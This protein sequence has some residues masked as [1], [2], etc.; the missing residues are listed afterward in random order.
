MSEFS[1]IY[2]GW[3]RHR[4]FIPVVNRFRYPIF[5]MYLDIDEIR[6]I[7]SDKW[8]C[9]FNRLNLVTF[10][11]SDYF[12]PAEP[13]LKQA[14]IDRVSDFYSAADISPPS[15]SRV[16]MLGHL[17]YFNMVFNPVVIYYCFDNNNKLQAI[18]S[19]ITNTPWGE[20][21][22]Y[23]HPISSSQDLCNSELSV[24]SFTNNTQNHK[25]QFKFKKQFHVSPFNPMNMDYRWVFSEPKQS[26]HI[27][28][29]NHIQSN[30]GSKHFDATLVMESLSLSKNLAKTL[31]QQP[32]IIVKV[33]L[34]IYYQ[35]FKLWLKR[36]PFYGH[37]NPDSKTKLK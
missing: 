21:H 28:M 4:R 16:C 22:S 5:M 30:D 20:R 31:I 3:I 18:L 36:S 10:K 19:E 13:D 27:H 29:D 23:V 34:G 2:K 8:Y 24:D 32:F 12:N 15:I 7:F 35:A 33:V 17:R 14:V 1:A 26:L 25:F 37:P 9:S 6:S 11:R